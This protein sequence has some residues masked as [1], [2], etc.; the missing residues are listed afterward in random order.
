VS[1]RIT[2]PLSQQELAAWTGSSREAAAKAL[3][4]RRDHGWIETRRREIVITN[5]A[6]LRR[7]A[8]PELSAEELSSE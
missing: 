7:R 4:T 8:H 5:L 1:S 3:R 6:A 2:L